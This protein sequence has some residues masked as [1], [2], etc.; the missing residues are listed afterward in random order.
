MTD[1]RVQAVM[2]TGHLVSVTQHKLLATLA[3]TKR[4]PSIFAF[5]EYVGANRLM[6]YGEN[7]SDFFQP[8]TFFVDK[9]FKGAQPAEIHRT[10]DKIPPSH[11][12]QDRRGTWSYNPTAASISLPTRSSSNPA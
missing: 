7:L 4:L 5:R 11:Q 8:A 1:E 2:L 12:S 9:I 6:S 3:L 10:A